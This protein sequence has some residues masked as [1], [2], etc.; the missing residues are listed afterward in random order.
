MEDNF[1][2]QNEAFELLALINAEF[3][4][5]PMSTQCFDSRIVERVRYCVAKLA[6]AQKMGLL[7]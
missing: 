7:G 4:S 2:N 5:D 1:K 3:F 6:E